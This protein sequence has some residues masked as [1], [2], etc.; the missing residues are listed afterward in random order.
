MSPLR[1][2]GSKR[3]FA[4]YIAEVIRLNDLKPKL[5]VEPFAGGASVSLQLLNDR[6]VQSI[7]LGEKDPL[8]A[9][10][11][12]VVFGDCEPLLQRVRETDVTI[13]EW[14]RLKSARARTDLDRAFAC[15]YLNR[16]SYSGIMRDDAGPIGG[17]QQASKYAIDCRFPKATLVRRIQQANA[18]KEK[19]AFVQSGDWL[20][21]IEQAMTYDISPNEVFVY[22]DPPFFKAGPRLYR[23]FF[24]PEN[25][26]ELYQ[27][28]AKLDTP[29]LLSYDPAEAI[30]EMY[31]RNGIEPKHV[32]LLYSA[33]PNCSGSVAEELIISNVSTLPS[34]GRLWKTTGEWAG[35]AAS[36]TRS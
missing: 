24:T 36:P 35:A 25:H 17:Y 27:Y 14:V 34:E 32:S 9:S 11:W 26:E 21:T 2:P 10:F 20:R 28:L 15:L 7:G 33:C 12:K 19:V 4:T 6:V 8:L 29:W 5:F 31:T 13:E 1:Y 16:T 23:H 18:L 22:L 30:V 3:R